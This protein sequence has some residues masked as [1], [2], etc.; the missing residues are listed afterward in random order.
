M[1]NKTPGL[2]KLILIFEP[3]LL[4]VTLISLFF[5]REKMGIPDLLWLW[6]GIIIFSIA[7]FLFFLILFIIALTKR[8]LRTTYWTPLLLVACFAFLAQAILMFTSPYVMQPKFVEA[9]VEY[10]ETESVITA[11]EPGAVEAITAKEIP[12]EEAT[13]QKAK[14]NIF[15]IGDTFKIGN[16][17][18]TIN[19][20]RTSETDKYGNRPQEEGYIFLF[21]DTTIENLSNKEVYIHPDNNF[22]MVDKNGRDY[23]FV[24][25]EGKG[26][27]EGILA[28]G[29]KI[30]GEQSYGIPND[31]N[32]YELEVFNREIFE[33]EVAIVEITLNQ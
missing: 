14:T 26:S 6:F 32:E 12:A 20:V 7:S 22:R 18:F 31:I 3:L 19:S 1:E 5:L 11:E 16:L 17:Q 28:P 25:A 10:V 21:I 33:S 2:T 27:I 24:W 4:V 29:R 9:P 15:Q 23:N 13:E 30:S 8:D